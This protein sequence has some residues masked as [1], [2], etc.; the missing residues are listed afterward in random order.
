MD[1]VHFFDPGSS[2]L[3]PSI[4]ISIETIC[5]AKVFLDKKK[6]KI[7]KKLE[8]KRELL[9]FSFR[10]LWKFQKRIRKQRYLQLCIEKICQLGSHSKQRSEMVRSI[11]ATIDTEADSNDG[12]DLRWLLYRNYNRRILKIETKIESSWLKS[13]SQ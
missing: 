5:F 10:F 4:V 2:W 13:F 7:K 8:R 12:G 3:Y 11:F 6:K 9:F 1:Q